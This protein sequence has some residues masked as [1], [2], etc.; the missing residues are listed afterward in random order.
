MTGGVAEEKKELGNE[1]TTK[2]LKHILFCIPGF[3]E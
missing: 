3:A 2:G 1:I